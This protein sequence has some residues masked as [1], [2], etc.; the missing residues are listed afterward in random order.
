MIKSKK[1]LFP[2]ENNEGKKYKSI[3]KQSINY[4]NLNPKTELFIQFNPR[5]KEKRKT[6]KI[7]SNTL[8][9]KAIKCI[10]QI[11]S[12]E[13]QVV[14]KYSIYDYLSIPLSLHLKIF[15]HEDNTNGQLLEDVL[16]F[17]KSNR[18]KNI[19]VQLN[20]N[21]EFLLFYITL[22]NND[23]LE[24]IQELKKPNGI[25]DEG[26]TSYM[27]VIL[28]T[29]F[30]ISYIRNYVY[31]LKPP[32]D[33]FVYQ[34]QLVFYS[35][36][37]DNNP[38]NIDK[39]LN[40]LTKK[41]DW[42]QP[43]DPIKELMAVI[44]NIDKKNLGN[45]FKIIIKQPKYRSYQ[46]LSINL[47]DTIEESISSLAKGNSQQFTI[48]LPKVLLIHLHRFNKDN[49]IKD[50]SFYKYESTLNIPWNN[51][52]YQLSSVIVHE[53]NSLSLGVFYS[54]IKLP[55]QKDYWWKLK[56]TNSQKAFDE[57]VFGQCYG[58]E[59]N[60]Y[61]FT[62]KSNEVTNSKI[63][64][65]KKDNDKTAYILVYINESYTNEFLS[66]YIEEEVRS[67]VK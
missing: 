2:N 13:N 44:N 67:L 18:Q 6:I 43:K 17:D 59:S 36:Q 41:K 66:Q 27:D 26:N 58:G 31:D 65:I 33:S 11:S 46:Y 29:L 30:W 47:N 38:V 62:D 19:Y 28:Q 56:E 39:L 53:G 50:C 60:S 32:N 54:F 37:I 64:S 63:I 22:C 4:C 14:F 52:K 21:R 3:I 25:I 48:E 61:S 20:T 34:L 45:M 23:P 35:L 49:D 42:N 16:I 40:Y 51:A 5:L 1:R 10:L 15:I 57:E 9:Y 12:L 24:L 8:N 55:N 7:A